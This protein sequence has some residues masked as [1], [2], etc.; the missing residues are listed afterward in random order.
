MLG[1]NILKNAV[2]L[3]SRSS[4]SVTDFCLLIQTAVTQSLQ[5]RLSQQAPIAIWLAL[6]ILQKSVEDQA[7]YQFFGMERVHQLGQPQIPA[8]WDMDFTGVTRECLHN[9]R[10][11]RVAA[12]LRSIID[13]KVERGLMGVRSQPS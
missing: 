4:N 9:L 7:G 1:L 8:P 12:Y 11:L 5:P 6:E 3:P 13:W 2:G 10:T